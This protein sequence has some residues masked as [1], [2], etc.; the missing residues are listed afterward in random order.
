MQTITIDYR[1]FLA[2]ESESNYNPNKGFSPSSYGIETVKNRYRGLLLAGRSGIEYKTNIADTIYATVQYNSTKFYSIGSAGKIYETQTGAT[3][4]HTVKATESV[5]SY[6]Y[7]STYALVYGGELFFTSTVNITKCDLPVTTA[8]DDWWT[9]VAGGDALT[10][11]IPHKL[12]EFQG[13]MYITNGNKLC[14]WDGSSHNDAAL[15]L[16]DGWVIVDVEIINNQIYLGACNPSWNATPAKTKLFIWDGYSSQ[17]IDEKPL[18]LTSLS[19]I[20]QL[21][22]ILFLFSSNTMFYFNG[23]DA[24]YI[25]YVGG[26]I[27]PKKIYTSD[28]QM[29]FPGT[30]GIKCYDL[31]TKSL[32]TPVHCSDY[33]TLFTCSGSCVNVFTANGSFYRYSDNDYAEG[34][35]RSNTYFF[36]QTVNIAKIA[37]LFNGNLVTDASYTF[38]LYNEAGEQIVTDKIISYALDEAIHKKTFNVKISVEDFYLTLAMTNAACKA[39]RWIKIYYE[40]REGNTTK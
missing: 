40:P 26:A 12:F 15:T 14:S 25:N 32:S 7:A 20:R 16:P 31:K 19:A 23:N 13:V 30:Y 28:G 11:C 6:A 27:Y 21:G 17:W 8:D 33:N 2:G 37:I 1:N 38:N 36:P 3:P 5:K 34:V 39:I 9:A 24:E 18:T 29:L 10:D 35:F 22:G 4:T